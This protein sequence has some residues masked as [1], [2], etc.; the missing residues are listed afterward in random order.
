[1]ADDKLHI[2][3]HVYDTEL[4]VNVPRDDEEYY[5]S[6]AKLIT[7]TVNTYSTLFKGKKGDKDIM[8]MAM[9]DIALKYKK[10]GVRNDTAPFND[11]LGKL[12]SEIEEVLKK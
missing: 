3:L 1:M 8:Y 12:T 7:D 6:A 4:S 11:I 9:L 5:R 10:E 2:R